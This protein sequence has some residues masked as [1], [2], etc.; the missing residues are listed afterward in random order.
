M[1]EATGQ[2]QGGELKPELRVIGLS[3]DEA[4]QCLRISRR[5]LLAALSRGEVPGRLVAN[6]WR[7]SL[8]ALDRFLGTFEFGPRAEK[9][10]AKKG[11]N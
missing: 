6:K 1:T 5:S 4:A 10:L 3:V 8:D 2:E 9:E 11:S 7:L